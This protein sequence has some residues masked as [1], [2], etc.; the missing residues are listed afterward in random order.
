MWRYSNGKNVFGIRAAFGFK[1]HQGSADQ[2]IASLEYNIF[3]I[4]MGGYKIQSFIIMKS[5]RILSKNT[6]I[7]YLPAYFWRQ[8]K[9]TDQIRHCHQGVADIRQIPDHFQ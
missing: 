5:K 9:Y 1:K 2:I 8:Q 6:V 3:H 7:P 4:C